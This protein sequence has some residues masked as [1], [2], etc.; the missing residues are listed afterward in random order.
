M[1]FVRKAY[2]TDD[3]AMKARAIA[4]YDKWETNAIGEN[5]LDKLPTENLDIIKTKIPLK[6]CNKVILK[7]S[8]MKEKYLIY[9]FTDAN[10]KFAMREMAVCLDKKKLS[11]LWINSLKKKVNWVVGEELFINTKCNCD[12][13]FYAFFQKEK[14]PDRNCPY[15]LEIDTQGY[16][17][18]N[19]GDR[20]TE[21]YARV[22]INCKYN[23]CV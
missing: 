1:T 7:I 3:D 2:N 16:L 11:M 4:I 9:Y 5:Y 19:Y 12:N 8:N 17:Y 10:T 13:Y 18:G 14:D 15:D 21:S 6:K 23:D 22:K 20:A